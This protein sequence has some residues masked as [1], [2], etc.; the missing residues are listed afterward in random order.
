MTQ[1]SFTADTLWIKLFGSY[2]NAKFTVELAEASGGDD[3]GHDIRAVIGE[4]H[5]DGSITSAQT[6]VMAAPFPSRNWIIP[7]SWSWVLKPLDQFKSNSKLWR[8]V[9]SVED[10]RKR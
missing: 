8:R 9:A 3:S 4:Q 1:E 6:R 10:T 7:P 5:P 2:Y